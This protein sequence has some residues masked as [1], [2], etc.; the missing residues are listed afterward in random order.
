MET[1]QEQG[2]QVIV[3]SLGSETVYQQWYI[4]AFMSGIKKLN[5]KVPVRV[6]WGYKKSSNPKLV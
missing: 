6:V 5:E 3:I 2:Q 4:D 1:A